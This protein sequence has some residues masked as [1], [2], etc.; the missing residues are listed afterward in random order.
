[1]ADKSAVVPFDD[2][3]VYDLLDYV[4]RPVTILDRKTNA[5][6]NKVVSLVKVQRQHHK[7]YEWT[8]EPE[9]EMR[10]HYPEL[11][12]DGDFE[13]S[14]FKWGR[15]VTPDPCMIHLSCVCLKKKKCPWHGGESPRRGI[16]V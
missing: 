14:I 10:E 12:V 6:H 4:E 11:F 3:Y 16:S 2:I 13:D 7:G 15:F 9:A 1:M 5:L 8:W